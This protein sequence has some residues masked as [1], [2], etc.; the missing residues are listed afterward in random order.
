M[1]LVRS[2][3]LMNDNYCSKF[4]VKNNGPTG[5]HSR[6]AMSRLIVSAVY[7]FCRYLSPTGKFQFFPLPRV[8]AICSSLFSLNC[9]HL[10]TLCTIIHSFTKNYQQRSRSSPAQSRFPRPR[11]SGL[12]IL[13]S[14]SDMPGAIVKASTGNPLTMKDQLSNAISGSRWAE[15]IA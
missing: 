9:I 15:I 8:S 1:V 3:R 5:Q 11:C 4:S 7:T 2:A 12:S 13:I 6:I 14:P 10:E